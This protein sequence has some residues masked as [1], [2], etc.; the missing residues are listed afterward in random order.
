[1]LQVIMLST[2]YPQLCFISPLDSISGSYLT[3]CL[4]SND[5]AFCAH[6]HYGG[7]LDLRMRSSGT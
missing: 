7:Q 6:C 5:I 2:I 4:H 3:F 1:M